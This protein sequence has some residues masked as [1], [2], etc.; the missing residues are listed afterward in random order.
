MVTFSVAALLLLVLALP[1]RCSQHFVRREQHQTSVAASGFVHQSPEVANDAARLLAQ[2]LLG[3]GNSGS[4][5]LPPLRTEPP[6]QG[7]VYEVHFKKGDTQMCW[8]KELPGCRQSSQ[9]CDLEY[10]PVGG[11]SK[12]GDCECMQV[13][14]KSCNIGEGDPHTQIWSEADVEF[15]SEVKTR[16]WRALRVKYLDSEASLGASA[17]DKGKLLEL[18]Q[19]CNT[20]SGCECDKS[21]WYRWSLDAEKIKWASYAAEDQEAENETKKVQ[22]QSAGVSI[23]PVPENPTRNTTMTL[24]ASNLQDPAGNMYFVPKNMSLAESNSTPSA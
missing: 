19:V 13:M 15:G 2:E 10:C 18:G 14:V 20:E 16:F 5:I 9:A 24:K 7:K 22:A 21:H 17:K 12:L 11:I 3:G 1:A 8:M 6:E 23:G 4:S